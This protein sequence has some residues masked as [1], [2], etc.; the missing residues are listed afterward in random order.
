MDKEIGGWLYYIVILAVAGISW[1][2]SMNKKKRQQAQ[3]P[4]S[5]LPE[6]EEMLSPPP[7]PVR[8]PQKRKTP[9]PAPKHSRQRASDFL[10]LTDKEGERSIRTSFFS[11]EEEGGISLSETLELTDPE[12]FRKAIV[13]AE[14]MNRKY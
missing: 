9:P 10:F 8:Q 3:T 2:N 11:E 6:I 12:T 13:Y 14:I 5:S 7:P 4:S 1:I